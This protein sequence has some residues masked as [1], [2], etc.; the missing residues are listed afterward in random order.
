MR[1][2]KNTTPELLTRWIET[3]VFSPLLR[4][5]AAMG[6][7]SQEPWIFGEPTLSIYRKYLHL[8][9][10]FIPYLYDLFA[11]ESKTGLPIMRPLVL[12][13]P[14]D[15]AVKNMNDEYMVGTNIVVAPIVEEGK[16][17]RTVYLPQGE[18]ID[19]W[20][21]VTYSGN[22]TILVSAPI[23]K[24][25]LFIKKNT[26][27]PWGEVKEHISSKPDEKMIFR[28]FGEHGKYIHYQDNGTDFA[29][30]KGEYNL[31]EIKVDDG[32]ATISLKINGYKP[33]YQRIEIRITNEKMNFIYKDKKYIQVN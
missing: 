26:I 23:D 17:C 14:T 27:L 29:Y 4:N 12:N 2:R 21:N 33:I 1:E 13:Y 32:K 28:V 3:A 19:F 18:W 25:P 7:R 20:N 31:Y 10:H 5:H 11:Q 9:Y 8:R 30:Q 16:N 15:P 24:L 6:T 22:T